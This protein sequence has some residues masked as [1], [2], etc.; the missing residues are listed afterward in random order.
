MRKLKTGIVGLGRMGKEYAKIL[1]YKIPNAELIAACSINEEELDYA[2]NTLNIPNT[3]SDFIEM[4]G[5]TELECIF[6]ISS[7]DQHADHMIAA[8]EAGKHVFSEKPLAI[9]LEKCLKV[10][11]VVER[12][13]ELKA[14][15]GFVRRFDAS[16]MYAKSM[17]N[18]GKIGNPFLVKSQTVD[19]DTVSD[20][21]IDYVNKSGGIFHDFNVHDIDLA[22]W[23]L[24]AEISTV[25]SIGGAYKYPAF[26]EKGDAD[27]VMTTCTFDNGSMAVIHASR[28]AAQGHDTYTEVVGTKGSLRIG[29][30]ANKNRV[31]IYDIHGIRTECVE[32]FW[33]RFEDAF[34]N[35]AQDFVDCVLEDRRP[36]LQLNDA[37]RATE[38]AIAF[39]QSFRKKTLIKIGE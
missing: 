8:L 33:D 36:E 27:N 6:V 17:V 21:Q 31:E 5:L 14:V 4:L 9:T 11:K 19:K 12:H 2:G 34:T 16:Y 3:Y 32:T 26:A 1:K 30:P 24:G 25:H 38:S 23:F 28:T 15:V 18:Q 37:I 22:R 29:R 10:K 7:T 20:F 39:T 35:M 13:K